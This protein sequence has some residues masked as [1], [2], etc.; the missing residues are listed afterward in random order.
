MLISNDFNIQW[1][2]LTWWW[3]NLHLDCDYVGLQMLVVTLEEICSSFCPIPFTICC[4]TLSSICP[5]DVMRTWSFH[6]HWYRSFLSNNLH[7]LS[8]MRIW[9]E[10]EDISGWCFARCNVA[11]QKLPIWLH[12]I[13]GYRTTWYTSSTGWIG[14]I[15]IS[16][17]C[18]STSKHTLT[19]PL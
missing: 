15:L 6:H 5:Q 19:C 18:L 1:I 16:L 12:R 7:H 8:V 11:Q 2:W 10:L 3:R 4:P 13:L 17:Q 9:W 14:M